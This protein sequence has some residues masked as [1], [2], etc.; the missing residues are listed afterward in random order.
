L[1]A[2]A[3]VK[4]LHILSATVL[5]GTGLGIAFFFWMGGRSGDERAALFAAQATVTADFLFTASA[6]L[7]QPLTGAWLVWRGGFDPGAR[8]LEWTYGLYILAGVCWVPVVFIQMRIR[9]QLRAKLS[10]GA[11]DAAAHARLRRM[12]FLLGWPAFLS[13]IVVIHLMVTKPS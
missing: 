3:A 6:V 5:F 9:D 13:L 10:G 8:W 12:W 4:T 2:Y 1:D 11:F 7:I